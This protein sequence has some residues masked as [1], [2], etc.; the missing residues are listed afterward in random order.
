MS[1]QPWL[2]AN[3]ILFFFLHSYLTTWKTRRLKLTSMLLLLKPRISRNASWG[4]VDEY[5]VLRPPSMRSH[6]REE[7][8]VHFF[9]LC[10]ILK[11]SWWCRVSQV[12]S[13]Q[14]LEFDF[15]FSSIV[16]WLEEWLEVTCKFSNTNFK[17]FKLHIYLL[18]LFIMLYS[19]LKIY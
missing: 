4:S 19:I 16:V 11:P 8:R 18:A 6:E 12:Q 9:H 1:V 13:S 5:L 10:F 3:G 15:S 2:V 7:V 14:L 17:S